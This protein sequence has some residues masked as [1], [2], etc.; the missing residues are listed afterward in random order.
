M[1]V[2]DLVKELYDRF[3]D[4]GARKYSLEFQ[5]A[6]EDLDVNFLKDMRD[7]AENCLRK[8]ERVEKRPYPSPV[9]DVRGELIIH[10]YD[11]INNTFG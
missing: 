5:S 8:Y 4:L 9:S 7:D 1:S 6:F 10:M 2:A 3:N 11:K